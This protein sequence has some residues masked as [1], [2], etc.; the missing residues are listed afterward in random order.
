MNPK[1]VGL[2]PRS[3][4]ADWVDYDNDGRMDLCALP[5][6][7]FRQSEP[8]IFVKMSLLKS[9]CPPGTTIA[10]TVWFD[11]NNDGLRDLLVSFPSL[12]GKPSAWISRLY[13]NSVSSNHWLQ[14]KLVGLAGN[15]E[16][17][18][19]GARLITDTRVTLHQV[20]CAEGSRFS[21][22]HYRLYFG[23]GSSPTAKLIEVLRPDGSV[24]KL[25]DVPADQRRQCRRSQ[26]PGTK[27]QAHG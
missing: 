1:S 11:A 26:R 13:L 4:S 6:R 21:Q 10:R 17:I 23:L 5:G 14:L 2:P 22:G 20:G 12:H 8:G 16:A 7:I 25:R 19:G 15:R 27:S 24:T 18:G 3:L 9:I